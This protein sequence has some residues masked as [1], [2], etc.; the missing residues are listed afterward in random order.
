MCDA[1]KIP[2]QRSSGKSRFL[3]IYQAR[4]SSYNHQNNVQAKACIKFITC[5]MKKCFYSNSDVYLAWLQICLTPIGPG[6]KSPALL[7]FNRPIR[8]LM[9]KHSR[10]HIL[11]DH[12]DDNATL[13]ERQQSASKNKNTCKGS[14]FVSTRSTVA[15]QRGW[16]YKETWHCNRK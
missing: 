1:D 16:Q 2:F 9:P 7:M 12:N 13:I 4:A 14:P 3:N 11:F 8:S 5:T 6:L 10:P 15:V